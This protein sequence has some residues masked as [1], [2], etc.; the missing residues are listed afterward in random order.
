MKDNFFLLEKEIRRI[1]QKLVIQ[2]K[3]FISKLLQTYNTNEVKIVVEELY[4]LNLKHREIDKE[5]F[6]KYFPIA[7]LVVNTSNISILSDWTKKIRTLFELSPD[8]ALSYINII[9]LN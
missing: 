3:D 4:V 7:Q 5:F 1:D 6:I 2:F 8:I 9:K